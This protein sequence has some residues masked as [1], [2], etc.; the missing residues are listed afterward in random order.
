MYINLNC[1]TCF[2]G[3]QKN[4][5]LKEAVMETES[6]FLD[7]YFDQASEDDELKCKC[8]KDIAQNAY[9]ISDDNFSDICIRI[10]SESISNKIH[11]CFNCEGAFIDQVIKDDSE[12]K[13]MYEL[14]DNDIQ[15]LTSLGQPVDNLIYYQLETKTKESLLLMLKCQNCGFGY[16]RYD[17]ST[18]RTRSEYKFFREDVVYS[19]TDIQQFYEIIKYLKIRDFASDYGVKINI[20]DLTEFGSYLRANHMLGYFHNVGQT[21]FK[22]LKTHYDKEHYE[23]LK[24]GTIVLRGRTVPKNSTDYGIEQ[25]WN[26]PQSWASHGRFNPVGSSVLYCCDNIDSI[27]Y[28][29]NPTAKQD[30]CIAHVYIRRPLIML[31]IDRLFYKFNDLVRESSNTDGIYNSDYALTNYISECC[32]E[33]GYHGISYKG[34]RGEDY[35]N[36]AI[37]NFTSTEDMSITHVKRMKINIKYEVEI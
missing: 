3:D 29:I 14:S 22:L 21:I 25:M 24:P 1:N 16:N 35:T 6:H 17:P 8:Q 7:S 33:I 28:E 37:L 23:V 30:I 26:P 34:V 4:R 32:K 18:D 19:E 2:R 13:G 11:Y 9:Y 27:P 36:Y 10:L 15:N 20:E 12:Y 5:L 31:N